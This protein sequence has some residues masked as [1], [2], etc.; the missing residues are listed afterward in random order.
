MIS[1]TRWCS[2]PIPHRS[3]PIGNSSPSTWFDGETYQLTTTKPVGGTISA[4]MGARVVAIDQ[5]IIHLV[6]DA[7]EPG[8]AS[9]CPSGTR[10]HALALRELD[11]VEIDGDAPTR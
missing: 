3:P 8:D 4:T 2:T 11:L 9:C 7:Y 1:T 10:H 5:G 6:L